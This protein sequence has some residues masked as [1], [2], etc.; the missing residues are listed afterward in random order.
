MEIKVFL[1]ANAEK[2]CYVRLIQ[3]VDGVEID[4]S[5]LLRA[6]RILYGT[7]CIVEFKIF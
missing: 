3:M 7:D 2:P 1:N 6:M 4:F 5:L